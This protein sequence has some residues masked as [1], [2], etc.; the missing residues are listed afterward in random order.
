MT[1]QALQAIAFLPH[2]ALLL[3][4][5][6]LPEE[7]DKNVT[8]LLRKSCDEIAEK[9][10]EL[11]PDIIVLT[12]PHGINLQNTLHVYQASHKPS[13]NATEIKGTVKAC[14]TAEWLGKWKEHSVEVQIDGEW[15]GDLVRFLN[16][17]KWEGNQ[18]RMEAEGSIMFGATYTPLAWGEVVPLSLSLQKYQ[19]EGVPFPPV[20]VLALPRSIYEKKELEANHVQKMNLGSDIGE[21][22]ESSFVGKTVAFVVSGDLAHKHPWNPSLPSEFRPTPS[23]SLDDPK[24]HPDARIFDELMMNWSFKPGEEQIKKAGEVLPT[25]LA[26]GYSGAVVMTGMMRKKEGKE[27]NE[28]KRVTGGYAVP[29]YYGMMSLLYLRPRT[30]N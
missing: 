10:F 7:I 6:H 14:G 21:W 22:I 27:E 15:S 11:R 29:T 5:E 24:G 23:T 9:L 18:N 28:W 8:K 19:R 13:K 16:D 26:C 20:I 2:G 3:D 17:K 1:T 12:T 30:K 4:T 25:A